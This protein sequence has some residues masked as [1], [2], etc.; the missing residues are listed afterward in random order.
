MSYNLKNTDIHAGQASRVAHGVADLP[1]PPCPL[2]KQ[3]EGRV[4]FAKSIVEPDRFRNIK[5]LAYWLDS[6]CVPYTYAQ[7]H[8]HIQ[9]HTHTYIH[10]FIRCFI[11][12][13]IQVFFPENKPSKSLFS[14]CADNVDQ[15]PQGD[16]DVTHCSREAKLLAGDHLG[17]PPPRGGLL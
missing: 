16:L 1:K 11:S 9:A 12:K 8:R 14:I 5:L 7:T 15:S 3:R 6:E 4:P 13:Y 2:H 10:I 17:F